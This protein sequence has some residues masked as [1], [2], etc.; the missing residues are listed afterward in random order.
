MKRIVI[1]LFIGLAAAGAIAAQPFYGNGP[2]MG[3]GFQQAAAPQITTL[4]GKLSFIDG[5]PA[6][7]TKDKTYMVHLPRFYYY[8][9]T[10]GIKE[11]AQLKLEG[12]ELPSIPGQDKPFF[13][14]TKATINGKVYDI[15]AQAYGRRGALRAN[16]M[17]GNYG[18]MMGGRGRW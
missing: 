6:I 15:A 14:V 18:P 2:M 12:Y 8:A 10:D 9:Y 4:D 5:Y 3:Y 13:A 7:V 16:G 11:G 17:G 1:V